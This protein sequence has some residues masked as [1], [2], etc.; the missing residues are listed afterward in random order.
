MKFLDTHAEKLKGIEESL[1]P[2]GPGVWLE[3]KLIDDEL[4]EQVCTEIHRLGDIEPIRE[5]NSK[6]QQVFNRMIIDLTKENDFPRTEE[7]GLRLGGFAV[8]SLFEKFPIMKRYSIDEAAVQIY[9]PDTEL[10]LGWHRDHPKDDLIVISA[11]LTG[12]AN[13]RFSTRTPKNAKEVSLDDATDAGMHVKPLDVVFFRSTGLY[14]HEEGVNINPTHC[15]S[16]IGDIEPRFTIQY[17]MNV[18]ASDYDNVP[19]NNKRDRYSLRKSL[20]SQGE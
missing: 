8:G 3:P 13:I 7:L 19:V 15:V 20:T 2:D 18:N 14:E 12:S 11:S 10:G 6:V 1:G 5:T 4:A 9:P 16:N 17:R